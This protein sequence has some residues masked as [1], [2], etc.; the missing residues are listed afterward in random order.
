MTYPVDRLLLTR[1]NY[2]IT[3]AFKLA[4]APTKTEEKGRSSW[5]SILDKILQ[6]L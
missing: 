5:R 6:Y 2:S 1:K 3:Q 4:L